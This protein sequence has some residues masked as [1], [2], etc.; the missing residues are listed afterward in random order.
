MCGV[1]TYRWGDV[2]EG[3]MIS[4]VILPVGRCG[5]YAYM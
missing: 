3:R 5:G 1:A 2:V 4:Y